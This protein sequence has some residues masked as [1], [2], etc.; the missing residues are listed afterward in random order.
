MHQTTSLV[1]TSI[2]GSENAVLK[3]YA[4]LCGENNMY[5]IV[6]GDTKSAAGFKL[7]GC[8]YLSIETQAA[9]PFNLTKLLPHK[10]YAKKNAAYLQAIKK[11]ST[12]II[13]TDDDNLPFDN[14]WDSRNS[15]INSDLADSGTWIN[16]YRYFSKT[17]IWPRGFSLKHLKDPLI[18]LQNQNQLSFFSP[19]QQGLVDEN[20]DVDAIYRLSME[21]PFYFEKRP[22]VVLGNGS[23]CPFNSQNTT[24]FKKAFPLLYLP[25]YCSFR[26]CDIWRSFI[27]QRILWANDWHLSFHAS[28]AYQQRNAHD[29]IHDFE[30]E[31][32]GYLHNH[33]IVEELKNL[34]LRSGEMHIYENLRAC[35]V[36]LTDKNYIDKK[37]LPLL[38]AWISDLQ[39]L[40]NS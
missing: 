28:N 31:I 36:L 7:P 27:A 5:F 6:A 8:E 22:T 37:E 14:F 18:G 2:Q 4:R 20:P 19:I 26:M 3:D 15:E 30:E 40:L 33:V 29:L 17:F 9:L 1:I 35:Y 32:S 34:D 39:I 24:W 25:S 38:E 11:G 16:I 23:I 13:E 21:L 12:V 10:N